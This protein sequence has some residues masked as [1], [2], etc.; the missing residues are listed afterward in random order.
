MHTSILLRLVRDILRLNVLRP[1]KQARFK[2]QLLLVLL[3]CSV[4]PRLN[5][6]SS[7]C[8]AHKWRRRARGDFNY[9]SPLFFAA[10]RNTRSASELMKFL[11]E[12][13]ADPFRIV[14]G[15]LPENERGA[16]N[17]SKWLGMTWDE[18][19]ESTPFGLGFFPD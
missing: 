1:K 6:L 19:V 10:Q 14:N 12:S 7:F 15:K 18:L 5:G 13:G 2:R 4:M 16:K 3:Y 8:N 9:A 11:L 17:L